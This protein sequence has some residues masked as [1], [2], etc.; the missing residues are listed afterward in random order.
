MHRAVL[1][2]DR[3]YFYQLQQVLE[4]STQR[5]REG[6]LQGRQLATVSSELADMHWQISN[7]QEE[8]T[9]LKVA[10]IASTTFLA[11][12]SLILFQ[13]TLGSI[14]F[15]AVLVTIP[16]YITYEAFL[17]EKAQTVALEVC[18]LLHSKLPLKKTREDGSMMLIPIVDRRAAPSSMISG[19][20][21]FLAPP[22]PQVHEYAGIGT[23]HGRINSSRRS[24]SSQP[25]LGHF[26][27]NSQ[28]QKLQ[29]QKEILDEFY[30]L[31]HF[32]NAN[33]QEGFTLQLS[34]SNYA[35]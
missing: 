7:Q 25:L 26:D 12:A 32:L 27:K 17:L 29:N 13:W 10:A 34:Q 22:P 19:M 30:I 20:F 9:F 31:P 15:H 14:L 21:D 2:S 23:I 1:D 5:G 24:F 8:T 35:G 4:V 33:I 11:L 18:Q 6:L 28:I 3:S 16:A